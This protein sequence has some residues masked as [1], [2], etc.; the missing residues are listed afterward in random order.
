MPGKPRREY[1]SLVA[2]MEQK[3][4]ARVG[5]RR[6]L[7]LVPPAPPVVPPLDRQRVEAWGQQFYITQLTSGEIAE[8]TQFSATPWTY[9][10]NTALGT[11]ATTFTNLGNA[12]TTAATTISGYWNIRGTPVTMAPGSIVTYDMPRNN[13]RFFTPPVVPLTPE[14]EEARVQRRLQAEA[15]R[16]E[17][18]R[19]RTYAEGRARDFLREFL[20]PEQRADYDEHEHFYVEGSAGNLYRIDRGNAGNVYFVDRATRRE[21]ASICAHPTMSEQWL[22][23][24]D[25]ALVQKIALET[26]EP[27]FTAIANVHWGI[28]PPHADMERRPGINTPPGARLHVAG[29]LVA[30]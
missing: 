26:D 9:S 23:N 11:M 27:L 24:Q 28:R 10:M 22:P 5:L 19:R 4:E 13:E 6:R 29:P 21:L 8:Y 2:R 20:N 12:V 7:N 14:E 15:R 3:R 16:Q 17:A 1:V 25:V 30:A 18:H